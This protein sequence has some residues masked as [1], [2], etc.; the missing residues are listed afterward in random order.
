MLTGRPPFQGGTVLAILRKIEEEEPPAAG[1]SPSIDD[2]VRKAMEKDPERR[3]QTAGEMGDAIKGCLSGTETAMPR[4][5]EA[6][7]PA[8]PAPIR[9]RMPWILASVGAAAMLALV[10]WAVLHP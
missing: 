8:S 5:P 4:V 9:S 7:A 2:L 10:S 3:I 1:V 6:P